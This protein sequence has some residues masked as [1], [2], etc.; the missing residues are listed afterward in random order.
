[1]PQRPV[2]D[3]AFTPSVKRAQEERGSRASYA[4]MESG[5]GWRSEV[6]A[7]LREFLSEMDSFYIGTATAE[8]QPYI[9]H[10]GGP[11][12]FL[13]ALD[14]RTLAFA[15]FGGNR[16][17]ISVG[18]LAENDRA[19]IFLMDYPHR[20]RVK[21]WGRAEFVEDDAELLEAVEDPA[22][23]AMV[24]R[25]LKFHVE[26]WDTNCP[27]HIRRRFDEEEVS[28]ALGRLEDRVAELEAENERLRAAG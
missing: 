15:D 20:R 3:V 19:F 13:K 1:M 4:K 27:Q 28:A 21:I 9:Q 6:N 24:E 26:A 2:S 11:K 8:G 7:D 25:A 23:E 5:S 10:R 17:Y 16:Q 14:D 18:N 22:Y 12:G